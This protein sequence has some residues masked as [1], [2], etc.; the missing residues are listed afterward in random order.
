M[1]AVG[2]MSASML[3]YAWRHVYTRT[4]AVLAPWIPTGMSIAPHGG[5]SRAASSASAP[6]P[7]V[8]S[9]NVQPSQQLGFFAFGTDN[10]FASG[11]LTVMAVGAALAIGKQVL[12]VVWELAKRQCVVR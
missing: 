10:Q 2:S 8:P 3:R 7:T 12:E 5:L 11:G 9:E 6:G 1:L 4:P